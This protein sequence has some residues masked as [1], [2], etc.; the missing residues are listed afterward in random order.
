MSN[1]AWQ[2]HSMY[3]DLLER[4]D[5]QN[6]LDSLLQL[7]SPEGH[8]WWMAAAGLLS[9]IEHLLDILGRERHRVGVYQR[10][11]RNWLSPLT[12]RAANTWTQAVESFQVISDDHLDQIEA[13]ASFLDGKV[14]EMSD[15]V[16]ETLRGV[17]LRARL[18]L[19]EDNSLQPYLR[20]Y[21]H[22]LIQ[23][24]STALDDDSVGMHFDFGDATTR[25]AVG[26]GAA[27]EQSSSQNSGWK[28]ILRDMTVGFSSGMLLEGATQTIRMIGAN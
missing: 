9:R 18:L 22:R 17:V 6:S 24:I 16:K 27:S 25:L 7:D 20:I 13:V 12:G 11:S 10:Q 19:E 4:V 2:L 14:R 26:L 1:P 28:D 23:E 5:N 21:I 3:G 8:E 15:P